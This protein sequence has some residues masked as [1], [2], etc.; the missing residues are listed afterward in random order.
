[1]DSSS[2][3]IITHGYDRTFIVD[4]VS[5]KPRI[6]YTLFCAFEINILA[7]THLSPKRIKRIISKFS[8]INATQTLSMTIICK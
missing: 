8:K 4:I 5:L 2:W 3:R 7:N 6:E 1:M